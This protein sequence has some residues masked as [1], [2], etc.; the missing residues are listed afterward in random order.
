MRVALSPGP[1]FGAGG[2]GFAR[3]NLATGPTLLT[4]AVTRLAGLVSAAPR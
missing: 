3:L 1:D 2:E 4:E